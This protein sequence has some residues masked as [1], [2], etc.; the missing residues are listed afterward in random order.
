LRQETGGA[1]D[2]LVQNALQAKLAESRADDI[3]RETRRTV[4]RIPGMD[5]F[6]RILEV[7]DDAADDLEEASFLAGL[8][9]GCAGT[10]E[11][12]A[13]LLALA[14]CAADGAQVFQ[15]TIVA[16]KHVHRGGERENMQRFLEAVDRMVTIEHQTDEQERA[17]SVALVRSEIDPRRLHL[18]SGVA[19]HLEAAADAL[20][21][22]SLMLRDHVMGEVMFA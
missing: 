7:A 11:L 20:L 18:V 15:R 22:A 12:P 16:A 17:V 5:V 21:R 3:V 10:S 9:K 4:R 6:C 1:K 14:N 13:S 2:A 8:L 19:N